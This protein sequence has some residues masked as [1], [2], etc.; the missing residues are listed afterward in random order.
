MLTEYLKDLKVKDT[1]THIAVT[2]CIMKD[3]DHPCGYV[4]ASSDK[5]CSEFSLV[6][7]GIATSAAPVFFP[8]YI[9]GGWRW[10]DGGVVANN[11]SIYAHAEASI[12]VDN[13][14]TDILHISLSTGYDKGDSIVDNGAKIDKATFWASKISSVAMDGTRRMTTLATSRFYKDDDN[15][16]FFRFNPEY[17]SKIPMD[18]LIYEDEMRAAADVITSSD[19]FKDLIDVLKRK[20]TEPRT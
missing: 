5:K 19:D 12:Y 6:D 7:I 1:K 20:A 17:P 8:S 16:R 4:F 15:Q 9:F 3:S 14:K 11:P 2:S 13:P 10:V 18:G